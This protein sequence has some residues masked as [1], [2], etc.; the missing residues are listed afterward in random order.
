MLKNIVAVIIALLI[1]TMTVSDYT[2]QELL[3]RQGSGH[4]SKKLSQGQQDFSTCVNK[5]IDKILNGFLN[6]SDPDPISHCLKSNVTNGNRTQNDG[7]SNNNN[8]IDNSTFSN[9]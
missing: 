4:H 9:V 1:I 7:G 8:V 6:F 5:Y 2:V 3:A